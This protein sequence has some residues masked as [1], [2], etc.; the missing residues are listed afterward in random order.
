MN[1]LCHI[2]TGD[3]ELELN[4]LEA[5]DELQINTVSQQAT[6]QTQKNANKIATT[7]KNQVTIETTAVNSNEKKPSMK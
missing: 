2:W 3:R 7:A 1:R 5:P 4:G 6:R